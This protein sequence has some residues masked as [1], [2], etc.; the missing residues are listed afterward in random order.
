MGYYS[1]CEKLAALVRNDVTWVREK[2]SRKKARTGFEPMTSAIPMQRSTRTFYPYGPEFLAVRAGIFSRMGLNFYAL[3]VR[4]TR[5]LHPGL[6]STNSLVV[7]I[8]AR[9]DSIFVF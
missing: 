2:M 1:D 4:S 8:T 7:F 3:S 5:T 6:I 9:I